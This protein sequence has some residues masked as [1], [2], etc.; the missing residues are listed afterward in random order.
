M[1]ERPHDGDAR[2]VVD[3]VVISVIIRGVDL[4]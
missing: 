1:E 2:Q 3:I 4:G